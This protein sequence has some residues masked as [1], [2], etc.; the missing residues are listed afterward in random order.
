MGAVDW[1][2]F[3]CPPLVA[4]TQITDHRETRTMLAFSFINHS[5]IHTNHLICDRL[6]NKLTKIEKISRA[7][8]LIPIIPALGRLKQEDPKSEASLG[9]IHTHT[10]KYST[11][12]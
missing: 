3:I 10:H 9:Y 1:T 8:C 5:F 11:A 6:C 12:L 4:V 2:L 7:K